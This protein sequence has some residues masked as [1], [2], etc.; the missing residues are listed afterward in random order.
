M[1][2]HVST[3]NR[4]HQVSTPIKKNLYI[5]RLFLI[6]VETWWWPLQV[7]TCSS[8]IRIQHLSKQVVLFDYTFLPLISYTHNGDDTP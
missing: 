7:E 8:I 5:Y 4:H 6:G 1:K 3:C 2:L